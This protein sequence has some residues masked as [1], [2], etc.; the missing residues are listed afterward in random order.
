MFV[1][2]TF[3]TLVTYVKPFTVRVNSFVFLQYSFSKKPLST[4]FAFMRPDS[5]MN[6]FMQLQTL[7]SAKLLTAFEASMR[8]CIIVH[9]LM[10]FKRV[11]VLEKF[12]AMFTWVIFFFMLPI[13]PYARVT[14]NA[15]I[16]IYIFE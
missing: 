16:D 11:T 13:Q 12:S 2:E 8:F 3:S 6:Q 10:K 4:F 9:H 14:R 7:P 1:N 15:R 5:F